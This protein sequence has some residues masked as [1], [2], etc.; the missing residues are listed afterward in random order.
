M[1]SFRRASWSCLAVPTLFFLNVAPVSAQFRPVPA[2]NSYQ[3]GTQT[4]TNSQSTMP[5]NIGYAPPRPTTYVSGGYLGF[6]GGGLGNYV[7]GISDVINAQGNFMI[8][9]QQTGL[10]REQV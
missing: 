2:Q 4:L 6:G 3:P 10:M 1:A 8:Q 9:Q 5:P 7:S